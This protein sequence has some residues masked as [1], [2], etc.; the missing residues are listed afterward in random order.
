MKLLWQ[1]LPTP[2]ISELLCLNS[3]DG[4]V[5]DTEHG[6]FNPETLY[7]CIQVITLHKK[8]CFIR[9]TEINKTLI[10]TCLDAGAHGIIFSTVESYEDA[11]KIHEY[12]KFPAYKGRRGLGLVR[13]NSWGIDENKNLVSKP[14]KLIAQIETEKGIDNIK[15]ISS[16]NF[17]YYMVGPYDLSASLGTPGDFNN[18]NYLDAINRIRK[19]IPDSKMAVHIPKNIKKELKKYENYGMIALGMDTTFIV[20]KCKDIEKYVKF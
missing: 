13:E 17:N 1:Q 18:S 14:P 6:C 10:R 9:L 3:T 7:S 5:I 11:K 15:D 2:V 19:V 4:V 8:K 16:L 20:E 12:C